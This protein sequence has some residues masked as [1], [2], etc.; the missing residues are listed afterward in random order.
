MTMAGGA[1]TTVRSGNKGASQRDDGVSETEARMCNSDDAWQNRG[2]WT[3]RCRR[4]CQV[5]GGVLPLA[6]T[7]Q[8]T[9]TPSRGRVGVLLPRG[10]L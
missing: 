5:V 7:H 3:Q 8:A 9:R 10:M 6:W 4:G 1:E 2:E